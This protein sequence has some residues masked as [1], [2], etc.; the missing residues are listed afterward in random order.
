LLEQFAART[1]AWREELDR[2]ADWMDL[3]GQLNGED[4]AA[5]SGLRLWLEGDV[6]G[7]SG[8]RT[9]GLFG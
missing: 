4:G 1:A 5:A 6:G 2:T 8:R 9:R 7:G 3:L